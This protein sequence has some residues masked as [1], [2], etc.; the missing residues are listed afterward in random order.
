MSTSARRRS[1]WSVSATCRATFSAMECCAKI[2]SNY[3]PL[4]IIAISS[5]TRNLTRRTSFAERER[6]FGLPRSSWQDYDKGLISKG[7]GVYPRTSKQIRLSEEARRLFGVAESITP[8]EL[9][10]AILKAP[11][12]LLFFGGIGTMCAHGTKATMPPAIGQRRHSC[13]RRR[14]HVRSLARARISE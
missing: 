10:K 4:S 8:Q 3:S 1:M 7:G 14:S 2:R 9:M 13:D 6:L 12:D 11:I 5:S